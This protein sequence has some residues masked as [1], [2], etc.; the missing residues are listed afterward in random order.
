MGCL[1]PFLDRR[2]VDVAGARLLVMVIDAGDGTSL[3]GTGTGV[4]AR[5]R[6]ELVGAPAVGACAVAIVGGSVLRNGWLR[7]SCGRAVGDR[8]Y[9]CSRGVGVLV[10]TTGT[11]MV[12]VVVLNLLSTR[13]LEMARFRGMI[14]TTVVVSTVFV[15]VPAVVGIGTGTV[16]R[17]ARLGSSI[18]S[19]RGR[20]EQ[21][22]SAR[23]STVPTR[24][25]GW[26]RASPARPRMLLPISQIEGRGAHTLY[27]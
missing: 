13:R 4:R 2:I 21:V 26:I 18:D 9:G 20:R 1:A 6:G 17:W 11:L 5:G 12:L 25:V 23:K 22:G 14:G 8:K 27:G 19:V 16:N 10:G 15:R 24:I 7:V 3:N